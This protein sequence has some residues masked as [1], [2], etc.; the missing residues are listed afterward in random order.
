MAIRRRKSPQAGPNPFGFGRSTKPPFSSSDPL[1]PGSQEILE[2]FEFFPIK[3]RVQRAIEM[4]RIGKERDAARGGPG[5]VS[6]HKIKASAKELEGAAGVGRERKRE[7]DGR[8]RERECARKW[9]GSKEHK[10]SKFMYWE[11]QKKDAE[12]GTNTGKDRPERQRGG[13]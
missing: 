2:K 9:D 5:E 4:A 1:A 8:E 10:K 12:A 6:Q 13:E 7:R 11:R 3:C